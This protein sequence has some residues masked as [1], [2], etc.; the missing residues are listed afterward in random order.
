MFSA[1]I[2]VKSEGLASSWPGCADATRRNRMTAEMAETTNR[3]KWLRLE[4]PS[5]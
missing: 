5:V 4:T 2:T 1:A 3:F